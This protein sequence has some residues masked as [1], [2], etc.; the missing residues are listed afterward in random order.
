MFVNGKDQSKRAAVIV[1]VGLREVSAVVFHYVTSHYGVISEHIFQTNQS[2]VLT[3]R[4]KGTVKI[5][6]FLLPFT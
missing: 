6:F 2:F 5:C 4:V 1:G 3:L